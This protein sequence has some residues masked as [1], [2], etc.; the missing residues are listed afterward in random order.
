MIDL[1]DYSWLGG[2]YSYGA[3]AAWAGAHNLEAETTDAGAD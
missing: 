2:S 1:F 3:L